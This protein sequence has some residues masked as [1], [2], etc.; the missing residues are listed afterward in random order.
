ME[1]E[2]PETN[3]FHQINPFSVHRVAMAVTAWSAKAFLLTTFAF[4]NESISRQQHT[5]TLLSVTT[6][7][8]VN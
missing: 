2:K 4:R 6:K 1:T 5:G 3:L 7:I 8:K